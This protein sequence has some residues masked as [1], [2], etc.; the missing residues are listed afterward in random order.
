MTH[1]IFII[2]MAKWY[3]I[4]TALQQMT[5]LAAQKAEEQLGYRFR[6]EHES[7]G[8]FCEGPQCACTYNCVRVVYHD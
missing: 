4:G 7:S 3:G 6:Q 1:M 2:I 8:Q 5:V